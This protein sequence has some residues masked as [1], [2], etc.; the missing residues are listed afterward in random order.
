ML[1]EVAALAGESAALA[2]PRP[3]PAMDV[4]AQADGPGLL[5][6]SDWVGREFPLHA[7]GPGKLVLAELDDDALADVGRARPAGAPDAADDHEPARAAR[8][9]RRDPPPGLGRA[10]RRARAGAREP[11]G[12]GPWRARHSARVHRRQ[13]ADRPRSTP[14]AAGARSGPLRAAGQRLRGALAAPGIS[15][16]R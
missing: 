7:S 3:G 6:V 15:R 11:R 1:E 5:G 2:V 4:I 14:A 12:H 8:R 9:A 16:G 13:R 10:R